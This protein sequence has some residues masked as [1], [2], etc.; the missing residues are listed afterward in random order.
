MHRLAFI[1]FALALVPV[2]FCQT[3]GDLQA[4]DPPAFTIAI[5]QPAYT[6][7][8][9]WVRALNGPIENVQYP[10]NSFIGDFG[11]NKLEVRHDGVLLTPRTIPSTGEQSNGFA[12]GSAAPAGSP[13]GRL[14][15]HILYP[16]TQPGTYSV[17]WTIEYPDFTHGP[18]PRLRF[19]PIGES[20][21]LTFTVLAET[22]KQHE[23]WIKRLLVNPPKDPGQLAGDFLPSLVADAPDPR[24]LSAFL[25]CLYADNQ[26]VAAEASS[27]LELFPQ[28]EVMHAVV[29][30]IEEH[31]PSDQIAY[32]AT[33]H[34]GWTLADEEGVVHAAVRYLNPPHTRRVAEVNQAEDPFKPENSFKPEV[35]TATSAAIKLL[36]FIFYTPNHA[37]PSESNLNA[38]TDAQ[39]LRAAPN[40]MAHGS[41]I[42]VQELAE[43]LGSMQPSA[44][45]HSLLLR[46]AD[47]D[48]S[49]GEQAKIC[50]GW[51]RPS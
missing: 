17:R 26:D 4:E 50:L 44:E 34:K 39:V 14:P 12:C 43:Y 41:M 18:P 23:K 46:I 13:Q 20:Q 9:V 47:R 19:R 30:A 10:F 29:E 40:I 49:A 32:Y 3:K 1:A 7:E 5:D 27:A 16:L 15:L 33:Y 24:A 48:D 42:A 38:W 31:G 8:P 45:A 36:A 51:H 22:P 6:D 11:C 37:W 2:S 25:D 21:W 35:P 28:S